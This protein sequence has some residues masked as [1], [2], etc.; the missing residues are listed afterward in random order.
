MEPEAFALESKMSLERKKVVYSGLL[1]PPFKH[2]IL[3]EYPAG[4]GYSFHQHDFYQIDI[5]VNG[6]LTIETPLD[7]KLEIARGEAGIIGAR[8][9]HKLWIKNIPRNRR[10]E[11]I[12]FCLDPLAMELYTELSAIFGCQGVG[13]KKIAVGSKEVKETAAI[14]KKECR[15]PAFGSSALVHGALMEILGR[16]FRQIARREVLP[17]NKYNSRAIRRALNFIAKHYRETVFLEELARNS[18]LSPG[19]FSEIFMEF[20]GISPVR[21]LNNFRMKKAEELLR[22]SEMSVTEIAAYLGFQSIHY[23]SRAFKK[24]QG[25]SPRRY[26]AAGKNAKRAQYVG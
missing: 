10:V 13:F 8:K 12:Q 15:N 9:I 24:H 23:F 25:C 11:V 1:Y 2:L 7:G 4:Y 6:A 26:I 5:V 18:C 19:R 16:I 20:S 21:Y 3:F 22:Y 14:L 17:I